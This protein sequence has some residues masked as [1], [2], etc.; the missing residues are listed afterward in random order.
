M[1]TLRF[2]F[3][4]K[5]RLARGRFW[6]CG[7]TIY[8]L[9]T[10]AVANAPVLRSTAEAFILV[11]GAEALVIYLLLGMMSF[12]AMVLAVGVNVVVL[13]AAGGPLSLPALA[14]SSVVAVALA[15]I[16][17]AVGIRRLHDRGKRGGWLVLFYLVPL[18]FGVAGVATASTAVSWL[19]VAVALLIHA[20]SFV[21]LGLRR[22]THGA[23]SFGP[24]PRG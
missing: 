21:E 18:L 17:M 3:G 22:G 11:P 15:W 19:F 24:D 8:A 4:F 14:G 2:L 6:L 12:A 23:N 1:R 5:G 16:V 13:D 7:L 10:L 9:A 20:W